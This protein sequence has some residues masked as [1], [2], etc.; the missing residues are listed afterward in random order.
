MV[1][2]NLKLGDTLEFP[3]FTLNLAKINRGKVTLRLSSSE[4]LGRFKIVPKTEDFVEYERS[5]A[6]PR[7]VVSDKIRT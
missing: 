3:E 6:K 1:I 5:G 4:R 7:K 2:I